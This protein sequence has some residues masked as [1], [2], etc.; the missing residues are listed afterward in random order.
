ML[1]VNS[2]CDFATANEISKPIPDE[3]KIAGELQEMKEETGESGII[4]WAL[5]NN[6]KELEKYAYIDDDGEIQ[7]DYALHFKQAIKLEGTIKASSRHAAGV[8]IANEP[9]ENICPMM[10][11]KNSKEQIS[12]F[13]LDSL[14]KVGVLKLDVLS[15]AV[16]DKIHCITNLLSTGKLNA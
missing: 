15:T 7:G 12:A 11:D 4:L 2:V 1:R 8:A 13:D 16:L 14:E 3:A 9:L 5:Q 10:Y 6:K